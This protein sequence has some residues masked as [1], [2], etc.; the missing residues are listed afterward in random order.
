MWLHDLQVYI[1]GKK[2]KDFYMD[3][4]MSRPFTMHLFLRY[5]SQ[6]PSKYGS[7]LQRSILHHNSI[8]SHGPKHIYERLVRVVTPLTALYGTYKGYNYGIEDTKQNSSGGPMIKNVFIAYFCFIGGW[9]GVLGGFFFPITVP[10]IGYIEYIQR[11]IP[12]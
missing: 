2:Y 8:E 10:A 6:L 11:S 1:C 12:K 9:I 4:I 3:T 7:I 5:R